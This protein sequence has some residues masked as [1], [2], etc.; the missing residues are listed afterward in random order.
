MPGDDSTSETQATPPPA[1]G[2]INVMANVAAKPP[3]IL[4]LGE[5]TSE[6]WK[7]YKQQWQNYAIVANLAAKPE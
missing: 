4:N 2:V 5:N 3:T 6:N 1:L 7:T